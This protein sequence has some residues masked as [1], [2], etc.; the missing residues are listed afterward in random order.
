MGDWQPGIDPQTNRPF[1][2]PDEYRLWLGRFVT[3][4]YC[5]GFWIGIVWLIFWQIWPHATL[6]AAAF[7]ALNALVIAGHRLLAKEEDR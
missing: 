2:V 3:C 7:F 5:A 6:I 4:P 1:L